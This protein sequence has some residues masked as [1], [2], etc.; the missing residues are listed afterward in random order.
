M[1]TYTSTALPVI[2]GQSGQRAFC[3][4]QS[5]VIRYNAGGAAC[6]NTDPAL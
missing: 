2:V 4:D 6:A 1:V 3:S 5:G